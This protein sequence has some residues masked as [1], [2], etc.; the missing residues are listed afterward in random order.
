VRYWDD[1]PLWVERARALGV[2][3]ELF[4]P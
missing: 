2:R 3:A 1:N 4:R